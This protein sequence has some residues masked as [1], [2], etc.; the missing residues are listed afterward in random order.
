MDSGLFGTEQQTW[1]SVPPAQGSS[2]E[3][4]PFQE[5]R[6]EE[7]PTPSTPLLMSRRTGE[8]PGGP[9]ALFI[10][11]KHWRQL[12]CPA[13]RECLNK[14]RDVGTLEFSVAINND[15]YVDYALKCAID[16]IMSNKKI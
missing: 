12:K 11:F 7:V 5:C 16:K 14:A 1:D 9:A 3:H 13:I 2:V 8:K 10:G 4:R 6:R 15:K